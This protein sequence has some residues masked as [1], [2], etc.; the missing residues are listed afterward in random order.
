MA[1]IDDDNAMTVLS[2]ENSA[3]QEYAP[4]GKSAV[5]LIRENVGGRGVSAF[6]LPR[7]KMPSGGSTTWEVPALEG[8]QAARAIEGIIVHWNTRRA[9]WQSKD[10]EGAPPDCSSNDGVIGLG[11]NGT[12]PT[13]DTDEVR[14]D[15][16]SHAIFKHDCASC[17]LGG[18]DAWGTATDAKGN[19]TRGKACKEVRQLFVLQ[20]GEVLPIV[21]SLSPTSIGESHKFFMR[22]A[23]SGVSFYGAVVNI[24]LKAMGSGQQA[25]AIIQPSVVRRLDDAERE[26]IV[27]YRG[28]ILPMLEAVRAEV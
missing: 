5:T 23:S 19:P 13:G 24:A 27:A 12:N 14:Y 28:G 4:G 20:P 1:K 22:M 9:Y 11:W 6:D 21:V 15:A 26:R 25:Y 17:P 2:K 3:V 8:P 10:T 18:D 7:V 16:N